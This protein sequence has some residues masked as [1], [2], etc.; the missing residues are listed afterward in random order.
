MRLSLCDVSNKAIYLYLAARF[1]PS[2]AL[3]LIRSLGGPEANSEGIFE[4]EVHS[5]YYCDY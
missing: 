3:N 1:F 2:D 4:D 5:N